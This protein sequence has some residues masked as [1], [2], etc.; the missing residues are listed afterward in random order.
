MTTPKTI[1][2]VDDSRV[3]RMMARQY[4]AGLHADWI[5][6][7]A[8]SGE[9]ALLKARQHDAGPDPDGCQHA[10]HGRHRRRRAAAPGIPGGADLAADGQCANGHTRTRRR[11][12]RL[13]RK[14]HHGSPHRQLLATLEA[15]LIMFNL[16]ELEND[17]LIEIFNIGVGQ[18]AAR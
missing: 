11:W 3:S 16:S 18:A 6:E 5:V 15:A 10:R 13:C 12:A 14:A 2:I 7:E 1:L 8:A 4:I 17:A 9:E